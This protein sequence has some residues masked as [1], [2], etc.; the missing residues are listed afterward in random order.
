MTEAAPGGDKEGREIELRGDAHKELSAKT[1]ASQGRS[2]RILRTAGR[3]VPFIRARWR[4]WG[5]VLGCCSDSDGRAVWRW[6]T[7][8][9]P[10]PNG[11]AASMPSKPSPALREERLSY[12]EMAPALTCVGYYSAFNAPVPI[13]T[14][15]ETGFSGC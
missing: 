11:G 3:A 2:R 7:E 5:G 9:P 10:L 8:I 14:G 15:F 4:A 6:G 1:G 12:Q 13:E